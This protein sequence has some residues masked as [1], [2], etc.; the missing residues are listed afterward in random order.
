MF[1]LLISIIGLL[2]SVRLVGMAHNNGGVKPSNAGIAWIGENQSCDLQVFPIVP[3]G[4]WI[5]NLYF[6]KVH[7]MHETKNTI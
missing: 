6:L 4:L 1:Q 2:R 5:Y 3:V 7:Q